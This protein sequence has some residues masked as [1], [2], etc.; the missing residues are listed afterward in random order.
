MQEFANW[1]EREWAASHDNH[2]NW[3]PAAGLDHHVCLLTL[4]DPQRE[5]RERERKEAKI[6]VCPHIDVVHI[7]EHEKST[8]FNVRSTK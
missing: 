5:Q 7:L 3:L 8:F 6:R 2:P 1:A 4:I